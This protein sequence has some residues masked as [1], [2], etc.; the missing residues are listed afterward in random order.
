LLTSLKPPASVGSYRFSSREGRRAVYEASVRTE[1]NSH[2]KQKSENGNL[3]FPFVEL[4]PQAN[5][6]RASAIR[7]VDKL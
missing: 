6:G 4:I 7:S 1:G 3:S 5:G 2:E